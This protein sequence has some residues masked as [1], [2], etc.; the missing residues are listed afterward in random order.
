METKFEDMWT[1]VSFPKRKPANSR[2]S[3]QVYTSGTRTGKS[4]QHTQASRTA[5]NRSDPLSS[6]HMRSKNPSFAPKGENLKGVYDMP[7]NKT[8]SSPLKDGQTRAIRTQRTK[9]TN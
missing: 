1:L 9:P 2:S 6:S 8:L 7:A 3:P 4:P 5:T